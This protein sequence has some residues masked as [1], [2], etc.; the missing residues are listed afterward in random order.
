[1]N[2]HLSVFLFVIL[3]ATVAGH[4]CLIEPP[5]RQWYAHTEGKAQWQQRDGPLGVPKPESNQYGFQAGEWRN[6]VLVISCC[7]RISSLTFYFI[8]F[9][10]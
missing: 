9:S 4:A 3:P 8:F 7:A 1:M 2:N 10:S 5:S 6:G